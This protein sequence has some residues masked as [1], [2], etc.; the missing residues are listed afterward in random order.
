[1]F[2]FFKRETRVSAFSQGGDALHH[3]VH[4][5]WARRNNARRVERLVA[6]LDV[7]D[8]DRL[9]HA[10][11]AQNALHI[12]LQAS[13]VDDP[14]QVRFEDP[15]IGDIEPDQCHEKT[16]VGFGQ[17]IAQKIG[18]PVALPGFQLLK[19]VEYPGDRLVIGKLAG[20]KTG[21]VDVVVE[22]VIKP[23]VQLFDVFG[24]I[25]RIEIDI[26]RRQTFESGVEHPYDVGAFV[27]DLHVLLCVPQY[28]NGCAAGINRVG[29]GVELVHVFS[30]KKRLFVCAR[31][32]AETPVLSAEN[33]F[34]H[35]DGYP[36]VQHFEFARDQRA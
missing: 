23:R 26:S 36:L 4:R 28:R 8:I 14:V 2:R 13:V 29:T 3:K 24:Q 6:S 33:G 31:I 22:A 7:V 17:A 9:S 20:C 32:G 16:N 15:V 12:R 27:V 30:A 19:R 5:L 21:F 25:I 18:P 10:G 1:M 11:Q 34:N 35:G